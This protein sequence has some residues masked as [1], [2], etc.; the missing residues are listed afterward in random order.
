M[1]ACHDLEAKGVE[2]TYL[3]VDSFGRV[4]IDDVKAGI[5]PNT[6]LVSIML[7]NNELGMI[8]PIAEIGQ[9]LRGRNIL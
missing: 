8:Q 1:N 2:I 7:A 4:S 6:K 9:Y 3:P 5:R